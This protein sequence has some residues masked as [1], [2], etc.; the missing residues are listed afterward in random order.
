M[1]YGDAVIMWCLYAA[2]V[3]SKVCVL[4]PWVSRFFTCRQHE[5][6]LIR[7]VVIK[8][9][10]G[11]WLYFSRGSVLPIIFCYY[12]RSEVEMSAIVSESVV[13]L[14]HCFQSQK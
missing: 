7:A 14:G 11:S 6:G 13:L 12:K 2:L 9:R 4:T 3:V 5:Y 1:R 10:D 8:D